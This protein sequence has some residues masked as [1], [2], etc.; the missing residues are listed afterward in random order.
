MQYDQKRA[1]L[2]LQ[3]CASTYVTATLS[4]HG[5][6]Q[7]F[8]GVPH[9]NR[10]TSPEVAALCESRF[11]FT[12]IRHPLDWLGSIWRF[13]NGQG[14]GTHQELDDCRHETFDGFIEQYLVKHPGFVSELFEQFTGTLEDPLCDYIGRSENAEE[15]IRELFG[16]L[17]IDF[18]EELLPPDRMNVSRTDTDLSRYR[19]DLRDAVTESEC[20]VIETYSYPLWADVR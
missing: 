15:D 12:F 7:Q 8:T 16:I 9:D 18:Q 5:I 2:R 13:R 10:V 17:Q 11:C 20:R 3:K 19:R 4:R 6:C 14:W 1:Y